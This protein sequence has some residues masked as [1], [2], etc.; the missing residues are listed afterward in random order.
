MASE[1]SFLDKDENLFERRYGRLL[2]LYVPIS[3][4]EK[5][6]VD[7]VFEVYM[8]LERLY[9]D[10]S[11]QKRLVSILTLI[12]LA[13][14]YALLFELVRRASKRME[15]QTEE[16]TRS[17]E[18]YRSLVESAQDGIVSIDR[19]DNVILFNRAA[20][21]MFGYVAREV[22]G[23]PV[24]LLMPEE[25]RAAHLAGANRVFATGTTTATGKRLERQGRRADG[26]LFPVEISLSMYGEGED[27]VVTGIMRDLTDHKALQEQLI[28]AER[29]ASVSV[30][31]GSIGHELNNAVAGLL[32]YADLLRA[33]PDDVEFA[34]KCADIFSTQ[35]QRLKLHANNLLTLS[36]PGEPRLKQMTINPLLDRVTEILVTSGVL[37]GTPSSRIT[38]TTNC[39]SWATRPCWNRWSGIWRSTPPTP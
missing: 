4:G 7:S 2:E 27:M 20:E 37:K 34:T 32:G 23:R 25:D 16:I 5:G 17:E 33:K 6:R 31:A 3:F 30:V 36:K 15:F 22:I 9:D 18:R 38:P 1:V 28:L 19:R 26:E 14:L 13:I 12:G 35:T 29:Q 11:L 10:I 21:E 24:T 39:G 8:N